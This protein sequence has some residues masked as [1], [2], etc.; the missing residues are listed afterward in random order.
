MTVELLVLTAFLPGVVLI[1]VMFSGAPLTL[2][3]LRL[4]VAGI[5]AAA[6]WTSIY[7]QGI[8]YVR[9]G[10]LLDAISP[11]WV[12]L[13]AIFGPVPAA[14]EAVNLSLHPPEHPRVGDGVFLIACLAWIPMLHLE[15][16]RLWRRRSN[17]R[18]RGP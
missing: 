9:S 4:I 15:L 16:V 12:R 18:W 17:N 14:V 3:S 2:W 1:S 6:A 7:F 5:F 13:A 8:G 11:D 10:E